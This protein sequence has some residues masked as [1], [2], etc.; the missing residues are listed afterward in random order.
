[1]HFVGSETIPGLNH[2]IVWPAAWRQILAAAF[3][4]S[5]LRGESL[6][7]IPVNLVVIRLLQKRDADTTWDWLLR[8][9]SKAGDLWCIHTLVG[10]LCRKVQGFNAFSSDIAIFA[11][12][13]WQQTPMC[14]HC[15]I[16]W[17]KQTGAGQRGKIQEVKTWSSS[18]LNLL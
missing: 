9:S 17:T 8:P 5:L 18:V 6:P 16:N 2:V 12:V 4:F 15:S 7:G 10:F 11:R 14:E 3:A 13:V 1:M